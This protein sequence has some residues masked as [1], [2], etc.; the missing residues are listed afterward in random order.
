MK[1]NTLH[2]QLQQPSTIHKVDNTQNNISNNH[3]MWN[4][5]KRWVQHYELWAKV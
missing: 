2:L 4:Y 1:Y 3:W 5:W